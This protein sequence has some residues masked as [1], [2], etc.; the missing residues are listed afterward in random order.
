MRLLFT[1]MRTLALSPEVAKELMRVKAVEDLLG[2]IQPACKNEKDIKLM[3]HYLA[4]FCGFIAGYSC[5]EDGQ[6]FL[7]VSNFSS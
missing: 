5:S 7:L 6:K 2:K 3:K 1:L 4:H